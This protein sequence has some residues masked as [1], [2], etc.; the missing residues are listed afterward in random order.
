MKKQLS[1]IVG[2][3]LLMA[4]LASAQSGSTF[5]FSLVNGSNTTS[6]TYTPNQA[7][8]LT[9]NGAY[10]P[11]TNTGFEASGYSLWLEAP[12]T[13]SFASALSITGATAGQFPDPTQP[14]YPKAFT[15]SSGADSGFL[16]DKQG[17]LSGDVGFTESST[18]QSFT[19][20]AQ[21]ATYSFQLTNAAPGTYTLESTTVSPKGSEIS[22]DN[23]A[24]GGP[25]DTFIGTNFTATAAYTITVEGAAIPEPATLSMLG[26]GGLGS[27]GLTWLR[28][29]RRG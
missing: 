14:T 16:S 25:C 11:G 3:L 21:L 15:D 10:N 26:L 2:C 20:T 27:L 23:C 12:T 13:N 4:G 1:I 7:F 22:A 24:G 6:A 9:L 29:R 28:A 18:T 5:S 19:G 17:T 8:T